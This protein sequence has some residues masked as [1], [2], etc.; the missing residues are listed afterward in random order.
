MQRTDSLEKTLR[1]E[2]TEGKGEGA[3]EDK[4]VRQHHQL[5]GYDLNKLQET[6]EDRRAWLATVHGS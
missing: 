6:L 4:I 1:L 2:K 3:V 5:I